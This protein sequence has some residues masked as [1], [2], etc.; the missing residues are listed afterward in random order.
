MRRKK[1]MKNTKNYKDIFVSEFDAIKLTLASPED[2]EEWSFGEVTKAE[3]INYRT[4]RSETDGL[5]CEKIF[6]PT[7]NY[8]CHCGKYKKIRYKG[9]VCD[10]CG[11]EVTR[12]EV[13]RE[14]MGHIDL[15]VPVTHLWFAYS[16]PSKLSMTLD[17][18]QKKLL[19]VI[20][21]TRYMV[22][23]IEDDQRES[24]LN[25]LKE[26]Q[27]EDRK[28]L[29][30]QMDEELAE[31]ETEFKDKLKE[32]DSDKKEAK[33]FKTSQIDHKKKQTLAKIR[34]DFAEQEEELDG[35]YARLTKLVT[36]VTVGSILTEDEYVDLEDRGV[37]F[38]EAKMGA[39]AI[40]ELLAQLDLSSEVK[41]LTSQVRVEK[42]KTKKNTMIRRLKY[43]QG[44]LKND[45][46]PNWMI[47][48]KIPVLPPELR[49]IIA[50]SGGKFATSDL[51]DLYRRIINRNNR[52][53]RLISIQA[54]D[55]IL[56]NEKRMLQESVDALIDN[57][58]RPSK[59]M[60]NSKK[61]PYRSLTDELR[62]KKGIFRRNLLGKR[63]DY[64]GRA[65]II[66]DA[67]LKITQCGLP[68]H[69]AVEMYKP[70]IIFE[71][72][73]REIAPNIKIAKDMIEQMD[74][75][76]WDAVEDIIKTRP[77]MLNRAPTLHKYSIQSFFPVLVEGDAIR[78]H[79][80]V[81]KAYNADFDGDQMAVHLLLSD[82]SVEEG[83]TSMLSSKNV[84]NISNG[85]IL[86]EPA[87]DMLLGY[88]MVTD[89][90]EADN[91]KIFGNRSEAVKAFQRGIVSANTQIRLREEGEFIDTSAGRVLF[92][93]ILPEGYGFIN[94]RISN[95]DI[96]EII[97]ETRNNYGED[98][99][100]QLLDDLKYLGFKYSGDLG[101]SFAME[102]AAIDIDLKSKIAEI[103]S[104]DEQLQENYLQ[105]LITDAEKKRIS[106]N[107][108]SDFTDQIAEEAWEGLDKNNSIYE[109]VESKANGGKI[110]TRQIIS[111]KGLVRNSSGQWIPL[112][113]KGNYRDGLNSFEYFVAS[114]GGRKG[115]ADTAL[116]TANSGYLTRKL[117]DVGHSVIIRSEDCGYDGEGY[118]LSR[119]DVRRISF[120]KTVYG[121]TAQQDVVGVNGEI[122][123]AKG[124]AIEAEASKLIEADETINDVFARTPM[125]CKAP[126]GI[127]RKCYGHNIEQ[128]KEVEMGRA[129]G[130][131]AAQ[132]IGEPST[133]MTMRTFHFG[134]ALKVDI[135]QG[136][137]RIE[138]VFE[139]RTPKFVGAFSKVNG[140]VHI[141]SMD[142]GSN[143][144]VVKG[145]RVIREN[146]ATA[147]AKK[148]AVEDGDSVDIGT[149]LFIDQNEV[150]RTSPAKGTVRVD[151][152]MITLNGSVDAEVAET[153]IPGVG[154]VVTEGQ[155]VEI[156]DA[157]SEGSLDPKKLAEVAGI[158]KAQ[159]Y[160]VT[161]VQKVFYE[162][163]VSIDNIHV[164]VIARQMARMGMVVDSGD[165]T[166]YLV[167]SLVNR[168][169]TDAVN[170][171]LRKEE[172]N[173]VHVEP[174]LIGIKAAAIKTD[175]FLSAMSFQEQ[176]RV[177]TEAA[178]VGKVDYLRG[179][180][181]NVMIGRKIPAGAEANIADINDLEEISID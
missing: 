62:G 166:K 151:M 118:K 30:Q 155:E 163:G 81:C 164:E 106:T 56:R 157:L 43:L 133:Q 10:K 169:I 128:G 84:I 117:C 136:L 178:I 41:A 95:D 144:V 98:R 70:F 108:W 52:L 38:F 161:E 80:L 146:Y 33:N 87:K 48:K 176:V 102:D 13:R 57:S 126:I 32:V 138:E 124:T 63:V 72:I 67:Q 158:E 44:F 114:S 6:G 3:T 79:P 125:F 85:S 165:T 160:I 111:I 40:Q 154:V 90:D 51:N 54:P 49:P 159:D 76:I 73:D 143:I 24:M 172:R 168:Y 45:V 177:L 130:I 5:M 1:S 93:N 141:E 86:A 145:K 131:I 179:M 120:A 64:S 36:D 116:R 137:P 21:Y 94:K 127:C 175:S 181:E 132:S 77:V 123:V 31:V 83:S 17:M 4:F 2:I 68:K 11:V 170:E 96:S 22:T 47:L 29:T 58:H 7:K 152:G 97:K 37:I 173:L 110:Q 139:A 92:N 100:V 27:N 28:S 23:S 25:K 148:V 122:I 180:K 105:G 171:L 88:F 153:I 91:P 59:A 99:M 18:P 82:D 174:K 150:E 167:G 74:K 66:G 112:P 9:L 109:M 8:E 89:M 78:I 115:V 61:L 101:F 140:Q 16:I 119:N 26:A 71:L 104:K 147:G 75:R 15:S 50:L 55:V 162:Q 42:S 14:R 20:Y 53:K 46:D 19:A 35:F 12:K 107:M 65:V 156:G 135:T 60:L 134:G 69:M 39:E 113:I 129:V 121:R 34:K 149:V 142:D 103:E